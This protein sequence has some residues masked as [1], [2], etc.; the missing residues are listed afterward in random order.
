MSDA[1]STVEYRELPGYPG[2]RV[3]SDGSVWSCLAR[4]GSYAYRPIGAW[5]ELTQFNKKPASNT[6]RRYRIVSV[7]NR[8][9]FVHRLVLEA[10][11]GPCPPGFECRH[12][13]GDPSNNCLDNLAWGTPKSNQGDRVR[14]GTSN[15]GERNW[16]TILTTAVVRQLRTE[17]A[18]GGI[19]YRK[20]A[21]KF[22]LHP[23]HVRKVVKRL[24]WKHVS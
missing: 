20:L 1:Q 10:F 13:D 12:L 8:M 6:N 15:R 24:I 5:R 7:R 16:N 22:G 23:V 2:Y 14:H 4:K 11:V 21:T 9:H 19:G 17:Y 18:A 3:G